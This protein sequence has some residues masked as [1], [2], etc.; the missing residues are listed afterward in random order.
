MSKLNLLYLVDRKTYLTKMSRVRFHGM[1]ELGK[2]T[3]LV[4]SGPGWRGYNVDQTVK[5]NVDRLMSKLGYRFDMVIAYK[6]LDFKEFAK[7]D[8]PKCIRYNEMYNFPW[9]T[10]EIEQ[11]NA[12]L[13]ICHHENDMKTYEAYYGNYHGQVNRKV[14]FA[15]VPHCAKRSVFKQYTGIKKQYDLLLCGH[16]GNRNS[17]KQYHY[18]LRDRMVRDIFPLMEARGWKCGVFKHPGYSHNDSYTDRPLIEFAKG[19]NTGRICVTCSGVPKSRFGKYIE[20]PMCGSAIAADI[21]D[22]DQEDFRKF[23]IEINMEMTDQAIIEKL[24]YYLK[25]HDKRAELERI[26]YEWSLNWGQERYAQ[27]FVDAINKFLGKGKRESTVYL[28]GADEGWVIDYL[29]DEWVQFNRERVTDDPKSAEIIWLMADYRAKKLPPSLLKS[30]YVVT[31]IH[32]ID[33][34]KLDEDRYRKLDLFTD[35]YHVLCDRTKE[36]LSKYVSKPIVVAPFWVNGTLWKRLDDQDEVRKRF[37]LPLDQF[38]VGSFQRDTEGASI[39]NKSY[40]PKLSKGPD[41]FVAVVERL[42]KMNSNVR[43]VLSGWRRQYVMRELDKRGIMYYYFEKIDGEKMNE[44]YNCLDLYVVGSRVEGGPRAVVE[45]AAA[46]VPI[47][48]TNV[49]LV[50][51]ILDSISIYDG[52]DMESVGKAIPNMERAYE[53]VRELFTDRY[54]NRFNTLLF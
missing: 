28:L 30:K 45:C 47:I 11:S 21:P 7:L 26:G 43:V 27:L 40:L 19:I 35:K 42:H 22:Q 36:I 12:D 48:S 39:G 32:H 29:K 44:L 46:Q 53:R 6:P 1:E 51:R 2:I 41:R 33:L 20:I 38:L 24:E 54:M 37:G 14:K 50:D 18:P 16:H 17:L 8:L 13:V 23:V 49:G 52:E 3:N 34:N 31:T 9:T 15:H 10:L 5:E 25:N 4:W